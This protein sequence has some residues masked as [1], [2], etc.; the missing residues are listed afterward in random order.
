MNICERLNRKISNAPI[1]G[2]YNIENV[3]EDHEPEQILYTI[4]SS[5]NINFCDV[6]YY[7]WMNAYDS[8]EYAIHNARATQPDAVLSFW[9]DD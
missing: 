3:N 1:I 6:D 2:A 7:D 8:I 5:K 9:L 4:L